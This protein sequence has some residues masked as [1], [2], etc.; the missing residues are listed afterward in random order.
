MRSLITLLLQLSPDGP[1]KV[2][3]CVVRRLMTLSPFWFSD[4]CVATPRGVMLAPGMSLIAVGEMGIAHCACTSL[5]KDFTRALVDLWFPFLRWK[6]ISLNLS[7]SLI[8][9]RGV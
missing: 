4:H 1:G 2:Q 9:R 3:S 6:S 7:L 8:S 5:A